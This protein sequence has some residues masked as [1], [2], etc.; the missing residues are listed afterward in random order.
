[1]LRHPYRWTLSLL[2]QLLIRIIV[3]CPLIQYFRGKLPLAIAAAVFVLLL[4]FLLFPA[5]SF[6]CRS[7]VVHICKEHTQPFNYLH[8]L[9]YGLYRLITSSVWILPFLFCLDR[10]YH[11]VFIFP[12]NRFSQDAILIGSYLYK[13]YSEANQLAAGQL[14]MLILFLLTAIIALY[15]WSRN[16]PADFLFFSSLKEFRSGIRTTRKKTNRSMFLALPLHMLFFVFSFAFLLIPVY[17]EMS[18]YL[19]GNPMSDLQ[20]LLIFFNSGL[21]SLRVTIPFVALFLCVFLPLLLFRKLHNAAIVLKYA[22]R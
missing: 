14:L 2:L 15:G 20:M 8:S 4:V 10:F 9:R 6:F 22:D 12:A 13:T 3:L 5:R 7:A 1:M 19:S 21:F 11:Y 18:A 16:I 17:K